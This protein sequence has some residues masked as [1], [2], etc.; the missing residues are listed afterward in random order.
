M[1]CESGIKDKLVTY[2]DIYQW[3]YYANGVNPNLSGYAT[4]QKIRLWNTT[5]TDQG[6]RLFQGDLSQAR[7]DF[8]KKISKDHEIFIFSEYKD[9]PPVWIH[10]GIVYGLQRYLMEQS[11]E[12]KK[13]VVDTKA[14]ANHIIDKD[15]PKKTTPSKKVE[16]VGLSA[17]FL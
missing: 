10:N 4:E 6:H 12:D 11:T 13:C 9:Y 8:L 1:P 17:L 3:D 7:L 5:V 2:M 16:D 14:W 15:N